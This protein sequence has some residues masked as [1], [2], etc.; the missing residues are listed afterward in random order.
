[1]QK[2]LFTD[3]KD[4]QITNQL[5]MIS[6][7][8]KNFYNVVINYIAWPIYDL[9]L[10]PG[11]FGGSGNYFVQIFQMSPEVV[12]PRVHYL[13]LIFDTCFWDI[14]FFFEGLLIIW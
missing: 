11:L 12:Y 13:L 7:D 10:V 6:L 3:S 5:D 2:T 1:M 9:L 14:F 4:L 8:N